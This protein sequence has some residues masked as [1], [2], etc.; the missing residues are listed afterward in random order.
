MSRGEMRDMLPF[1]G[2]SICSGR[3]FNV[4]REGWRF[5]YESM[6]RR[7]EIA[8]IHTNAEAM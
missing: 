7:I 1:V 5:I 6:S 2:F 4:G 8:D 3:G